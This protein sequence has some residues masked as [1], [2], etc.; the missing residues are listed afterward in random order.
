M[1][2]HMIGFP[3]VVAI[4]FGLTACADGMYESGYSYTSVTHYEIPPTTVIVHDHTPYYWRHRPDYYPNPNV[5]VH[6]G[7]AQPHYGPPAGGSQ[8]HYG[9]P[10]GGGGR[11][12]HYGPPS[13]GSRKPHYGPPRDDGAPNR[14]SE[15]QVVIH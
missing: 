2:K 5:V 10:N 14:S 13:A 6:G 1:K 7:G 15:T 8:P 9:P 4:A 12:P 11:Q 3:V